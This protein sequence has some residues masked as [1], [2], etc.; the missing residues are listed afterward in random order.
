MRPVVSA[1]SQHQALQQWLVEGSGA[2][3]QWLGACGAGQLVDQ[4]SLGVLATATGNL[5]PQPSLPTPSLV[6]T[7]A[8][9]PSIAC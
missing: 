1:L 8:P 7:W 5:R 4:V 3:Q 2:L 9:I 6:G